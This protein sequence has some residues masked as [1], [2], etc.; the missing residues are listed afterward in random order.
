M[1]LPKGQHCFSMIKEGEKRPRFAMA[2]WRTAQKWR[3]PQVVIV[4]K[5]VENRFG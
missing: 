2:H 3:Y 4:P 1:Q 5:W